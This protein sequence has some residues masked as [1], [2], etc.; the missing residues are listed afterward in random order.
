MSLDTKLNFCI[1]SRANADTPGILRKGYLYQAKRVGLRELKNKK[2]IENHPR[3]LKETS[4]Y[5]EQQLLIHHSYSSKKLADNIRPFTLPLS[6][7]D[8]Y[9]KG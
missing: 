5:Q 3:Y 8:K 6:T 2:G 4:K 7:A 9:M 1:L